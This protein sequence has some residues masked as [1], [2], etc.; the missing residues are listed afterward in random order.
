SQVVQLVA[1]LARLLRA[2]AFLLDYPVVVPYDGAAERWTGLRRQRRAIVTTN[3][4]VLEDGHPML[5]DREGRAAV[6]AWPLI[7][8]IAPSTGAAPGLFVCGGRG[9]PGARLVARPGGFE[10]H[11]GQLGE[12]LGEHVIGA[13]EGAGGAAADERPPYLGLATFS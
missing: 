7:Q 6:A 1:E 9:R 4:V 12:W 10:H 2:T 5:I 3:D 13:D 8:A 11:D